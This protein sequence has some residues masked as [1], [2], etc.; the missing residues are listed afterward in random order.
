MAVKRQVMRE[1]GNDN[2]LSTATLPVTCAVTTSAAAGRRARMLLQSD[3]A[4]H[5]VCQ[6]R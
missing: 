4:R 5:F 2:M 3:W 1:S 6:I